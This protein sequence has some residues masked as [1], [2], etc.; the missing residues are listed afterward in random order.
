MSTKQNPLIAKIIKRY[1]DAGNRKR[2]IN[3]SREWFRDYN[4]Q[5]MNNIR[6][7]RLLT[8]HAMFTKTPRIGDLYMFW[9]D[10]KH[11]KTLPYYDRFPLVFFFDINKT[12]PIG[13]NLHY[14]PPKLRLMLFSELLSTRNERRYR[15]TTR[16]KLAWEVIK[17]FSNSPIAE[18]CVKQYHWKHF[19]GQ[20]VKVDPA[21]WEIVVTLPIERFEK[22]S[23]NE[24]WADSIKKSKRKRKK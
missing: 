23:I 6:I 19:R 24:V 18:S 16:L 12:G 2:N 9:Y 8:D 7:P 5:Y 3:K 17:R 20:F 13:L 15:E 11:K 1:E 4:R 21:V 10:P 22:K 14:L